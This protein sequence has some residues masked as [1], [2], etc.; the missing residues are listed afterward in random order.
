MDNYIISST[1][2]NWMYGLDKEYDK[3]KNILDKKKLRYI[4]CG[5]MRCRSLALTVKCRTIFK[6]TVYKDKKIVYN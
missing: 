6:F 1:G 2:R 3:I 5:I 4:K